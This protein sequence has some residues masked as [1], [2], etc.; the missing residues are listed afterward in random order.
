MTSEVT[1]AEFE[2][3]SSFGLS[4]VS[5]R[6]VL[7]GAGWAVPAVMMSTAVPAYAA[8]PSFCA[9]A[10][11]LF[12][13]DAR[14][15]LL[16]G[17]LL[18]TNFDAENLDSIAE[19][20]NAIA[21][22]R[23]GGGPFVEV[24][25]PLGATALSALRLQLG[26]LAGA[27]SDLLTS[28]TNADVGVVN[29]Y[30]YAHEQPGLV[31]GGYS[32]GASGAVNQAN[33]ALSFSKADPGAPQLGSLN[34]YE[35]LQQ[36][37]NESPN[38]PGLGALVAAIA[39]LDLQ[40]GA[41]GGL[42]R[43]DSLCQT[44]AEA[45]LLR[46]YVIA[47]LRLVVESALVG[48]LVSVL[49]G[50]TTLNVSTDAIWGLL[51]AVPLL[52]PLL[53]ALGQ[54]ALT[55]TVTVDTQQLI[56]VPIPNEPNP[57]LQLDLPNGTIVLDVERLLGGM[58]DGQSEKLNGQPPNSQLFVDVPLPTGGITE[59]LDQVIADSLLPRIKELVY[60]KISAGSTSGLLATGLLIEGTLN[61]FLSGQGTAVLVLLGAPVN[62]GA[63]L[64]PLLTSIGNLVDGV[65][66][67]L[68]APGGL[69]NAV[70][71]PINVLLE[72]LFTVLTQVIGIYVNRQWESPRDP[73]YTTGNSRVQTARYHEAALHLQ[74][75]G[76]LH[77]LDLRLATGYS[78]YHTQRP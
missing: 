41:V 32:L 5:R 3:G 2:P 12:D 69:L 46:Q 52:G 23:A 13:T 47:Y 53:A 78:G 4:G 66:N 30:A 15:K 71:D 43:L 72:N 17:T 68:V 75:V 77:L 14:G 21:Q 19:V 31:P 48:N 18:N 38:A 70:L 36:L 76:L 27:V 73:A 20:W 56:G 1:K 35:V 39:N 59:I 25:S 33:G 54:N 63:A 37:L 50:L 64:G 61:Q 40:I 34:L 11:T 8:S 24:S 26:P 9:P 45:E 51:E 74:A 10:G 28:L 6:N 44:P 29:Q 57:A 55:V 7:I 62:L 65:V 58:Y 49:A 42:S 16:A 67:G 60:I 22:E